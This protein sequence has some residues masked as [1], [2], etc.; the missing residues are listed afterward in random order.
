MEN[1]IRGVIQS[2]DAEVVSDP[3]RIGANVRS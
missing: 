1:Y 2:Q 3:K